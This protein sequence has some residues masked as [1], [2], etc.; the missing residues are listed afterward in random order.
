MNHLLFYVSNKYV[1]TARD[2]IAE[3]VK[4]FYTNFDEINEA[5]KLLYE[6]SNR[7]FSTR[8]SDDKS[9]KT[10]QD[11]VEAFVIC[12]NNG[13]TL[14]TFA[15]TDYSRIP[16]TA[17]GAVTMEQVLNVVNLMNIRLGAVENS[18]S[19]KASTPDLR[20]EVAATPSSPADSTPME[21]VAEF[22]VAQHRQQPQ[23]QQLRQQP[24]QPQQNRRGS[25]SAMSTLSS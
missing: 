17:D 21:A 15:A 1:T 14:P 10:A 3:V 20:I 19:G 2:K 5:K 23:Q 18:L 6:K 12:D 13:I 24:R 8:R 11:I 9:M 25:F 7:N 4:K 22:P 16:I